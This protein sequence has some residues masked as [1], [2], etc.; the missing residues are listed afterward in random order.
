MRGETDEI[1]KVNLTAEQKKER[2]RRLFRYG[3]RA[4]K[5]LLLGLLSTGLAVLFDLAGPY[6][7]GRIVDR[8]LK[9]GTGVVDWTVLFGLLA[10]YLV[11]MILA[12]G[13]R[14]LAG[15]NLQ[16]AANR[17]A[18]YIQQDVFRHVHTL[19]ISYFDSL[20]AGTV[21]SRVTNDTSAV[22][23]LFVVVLSQLLTASAYALGIFISL[24]LLDISLFFISLIMMPVLALIFWDFRRKSSQYN[25]RYRKN[26]STLNGSLNENIQGMEVIQA[27][28][29]EERIDKE[30]NEVNDSVFKEAVNLTKLYAYSS[31]NATQTLQYIMMGAVLLYFGLGSLTASYVVPIGNLYIFIDFMTKLFNQVNNAMMRVGDLERAL[32]AADHIFE[33]MEEKPDSPGDESPGDLKGSVKFEHITFAYKDE[34]VLKDISF[35][36]KQ[37]ETIAFVGATGSGKSTI[38]N[39]L[40]GFYRPQEGE[41]WLDQHPLS[42]LVKREARTQMAIVQQ[43]PYLFTGT[44]LSNITLS[45]PDITRNRACAALREVGGGDFLAALSEGIETPVREKGNEFSAGERQLISFARALAKDPKILVLDEATA[46]IDSETENTIQKGIERLKMGRTTFMIAHRLSTIRHADQIVVLDHGRIVEEGT[47]DELILHKGLYWKMYETQST[48]ATA[49]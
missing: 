36:V 29:Q 39:L 4:K 18:Q 19:P 14:L 47:H 16:S 26:L 48:H 15:M 27:L 6:T 9:E 7:I 34:A 28:G 3:F 20:P 22:R 40:L 2:N 37:G 45:Q 38:M 24:I 44:I 17:V 41:I 21:V 13:M 49:E 31:F 46:S 23:N 35:S 12:A 5:P 10:F 8:E 25:R 1:E 30:F 32:S 11:C 43:E 33:L 42:K